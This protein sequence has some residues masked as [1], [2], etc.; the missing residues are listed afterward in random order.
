MRPLIALM[1]LGL[2]APA[3]AQRFDSNAPIDVDAGR[4]DVADNDNEAIFSGAVV[5]RQGSMT[6][7]ADRVRITYAKD[8]AGNPQVQRLD[9]LGNVRIRQDNMRAT[10]NSGIYDVN[11]R[12]VTLLGNVKMDRDTNHLEG[13]RVVWNLA[14]RTSSFDARSAANPGGR[15]TG[16]FTVPQ[17][18]N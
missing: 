14:T 9:A 10:S 3:V 2:A 1:L 8:A 11:A 15:V 4:I 12:L 18:P 16:R 5:I 13:A 7:N 6:L 17:K